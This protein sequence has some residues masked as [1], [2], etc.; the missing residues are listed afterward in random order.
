MDLPDLVARVAQNQVWKAA[1][2]KGRTEEDLAR[3]ENLDELVT[4]AAEWMPPPAEDG[5]ATQTILQQLAAW[6]E[7]VALVSDADMIDPNSV[8]SR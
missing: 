2:R 6:L 7:S 1:H 3:L 5:T 4:A 8:P